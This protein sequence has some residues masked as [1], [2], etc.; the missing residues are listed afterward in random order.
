[1]SAGPGARAMRLLILMLAPFAFATGTFVFAGVLAPMAGDLGVSVSAAG[2]LQAGF[3]LACAIA[4]PVLALATARRG[5]KAML[6]VA[7][8]GVT[9]FNALSALAPGY[10]T[11]MATRIAAGVLGSMTIPMASTIAV[12]LVGP[13]RR[14]RA[15][16]LVY[17]GISLAFLSGIPLGTLAGTAFGWEASFWLAAGLGAAVLIAAALVL[18]DVPAPPAPEGGALARVRAWPVPGYLLVTLMAFAA[19]FSVVGYVGPVITRLTGFGG[20]GIGAL[21]MITGAGSMLGLVVGTRMAERG[22]S[23]PLVL[24]FAAILLAQVLLSAGLLGGAAG[25][26][27][28]AICVTGMA[29]GSTALFGT[30]PI[31]QSRLAGAAGP[32]ATL[33]FA[34]NGS[35]VYFGQGLGVVLG[36]LALARFGLDH[37]ALAGAGVALA[38]IALAL[39]LSRRREVVAAAE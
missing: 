24:L 32:A 38:G 28:L 39:A 27:G 4:G 10:G 26:A 3:A 31:V 11:L 25:G 19:I 8:G 37:V 2:Q 30:A 18:P 6:L 13:E 21:Q 34:L 36:G 9:L 20:G 35:M 23:R 1:M 5:R 12:A 16:A 22:V 33:A 29:L 14:A 15:L 17:G 7:L